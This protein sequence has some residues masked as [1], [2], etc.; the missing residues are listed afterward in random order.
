M[1]ILKYLDN[2]GTRFGME[3]MGPAKGLL[4]GSKGSSSSTATAN[5]NPIIEPY[6]KDITKRAQNLSNQAYVPYTGERVAGFTGDQ[7]QAQNMTRDMMGQYGSVFGDALNQFGQLSQQAM[8]NTQIDPN[9]I[10]ELMNPYAQQVIDRTKTG[11]IDDYQR[12]MA[13]IGDQAV[14]MGAFGGS[15]QGVLE[16]MA[17]QGLYDTL[18]DVQYRGLQDAYNQGLGATVQEMGLKNQGLGLAGNMLGQQVGSAQA[19]QQYGLTDAQA[20]GQSGLQQQ[21][22]QQLG[23]DV[24]YEDFLAQQE[25]PYTKLSYF[26]SIVSPYAGMSMGQTNTQQQSGGSGGL[27]GK[28][29]GAG[30]S[31]AGST[32]GNMTLSALPFSDERVKENIKE[33]GEL[34]NG[35][36]VYAYNYKGEPKNRTQ[37]GV[38]AQEVEKKNPDAVK[39]TSEGIKMVDYTKA[40]EDNSYA[41]GGMI[42]RG[43]T[44]KALISSAPQTQIQRAQPQ[45]MTQKEDEGGGIGD[46]LGGLMGAGNEGGASDFLGN[47]VFGKGSQAQ[48]DRASN[49][50]GITWNTGKE[51]SNANFIGNL[52]NFADNAPTMLDKFTGFLGGLTG[53]KEGGFIDYGNFRE[54]GLMSDLKVRSKELTEGVTPSLEGMQAYLG[55]LISSPTQMLLDV[56][57]SLEQARE[58]LTPQIE[59]RTPGE[60]YG[61]M[62]GRQAG[63]LGQMALSVPGSILEGSKA[64]GEGIVQTP[65]FLADIVSGANFTEEDVLNKKFSPQ[66]LTN[67]ATDKQGGLKDLQRAQKR[68]ND[69]LLQEQL[70]ESQRKSPEITTAEQGIKQQAIKQ[71]ATP[72]GSSQRPSQPQQMAR[73][74]LRLP[75]VQQAE[76]LAGAKEKEQGFIRN[77]A[78]F[79]AGLA[80]MMSDGDIF[81]QLGAGGKAFAA[82][83]AAK[84]E[85]E[86]AQQEKLAKAQQQQFENQIALEKLSHDVM[87]AQAS[88]ISARR[89]R[90]SGSSLDPN[91][92]ITDLAEDTYKKAF[93]YALS[94]DED[95]PVSYANRERQKFLDLQTVNLEG[96]Q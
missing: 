80:M 88:M 45:E 11:V 65:E 59:E 14:N 63:N 71:V 86:E 56:N 82:T 92:S 21:A 3:L 20:L 54:G 50:E 25:D 36:S 19:G 93:E 79:N 83:K 58:V 34:D 9:R 24:N 49:R 4:G 68:I 64:L 87:K 72:T 57:P 46:L 26:N 69:R 30:M 39:E 51:G 16:G 23:L 35:L 91:K 74:I 77:E 42:D 33:V 5:F 17:T 40:V 67:L 75:P 1:S 41:R 27:F 44:L 94:S 53:F 29:L 10:Q 6:V 37:I 28:I 70:L 76:A 84:A 78:L 66:D 12:S 55:N 85:A 7:T 31:A 15:R 62:L 96:F 13:G 32:L 61:N 52:T 8:G 60:S 73:D 18:G 2:N 47:M 43:D 22:L 95:D 90:T 48:A 89:D 81:E 38:M